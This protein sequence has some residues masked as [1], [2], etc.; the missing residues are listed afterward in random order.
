MK[1]KYL[2]T[3]ETADFLGMHYNSLARLRVN[4]SGPRY[5]KLNNLVF[6]LIDDLKSYQREMLRM[7]EPKAVK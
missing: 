2:T 5:Y 6:Y 7:V 1:N 3:R 4:K